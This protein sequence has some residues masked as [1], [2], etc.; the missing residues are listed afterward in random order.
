MVAWIIVPIMPIASVILSVVSAILFAIST[1]LQQNSAQSYS[2]ARQSARQRAWLPVLGLLG[3]L[4]RDPAWL[5]GWLLN[6]LGFAAHAVALHLGSIAMVQAILVVQ[7]MLALMITAARR[8]LQ[9]TP[10]DWFATAFVC[11]GVAMLVLLRG[12]V[13]QNPAPRR[14]V[15]L[16]L[17]LAVGFIASILVVARG[18]GR[19]AQTRTALVAVGA[20][21]SFCVTAVFVV[22]VADDIASGGPRQALSWPLLCLI[23][24]AMTG[25]LLVQ[26]SFASGSL[27]T[28]LT[29]MTITDPLLS[30]VVGAVL[31]DAAPP[32]GLELYLGLPAAGLLIAAG[33]VL[34]ANPGHVARRQ[35]RSTVVPAQHVPRPDAQARVSV[36]G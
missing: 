36:E 18:I 13:G 6:V 35:A 34:L 24:S 33:V 9:P 22:V 19:R 2:L 15:A 11:T 14:D 10:R 32:A 7:L 23:G 20:G 31:F 17:A 29:A 4:L 3:R 30:S 21:T 25:S 28:A 8:S 1:V 27:P 16:F 26:D 12:E 5:V